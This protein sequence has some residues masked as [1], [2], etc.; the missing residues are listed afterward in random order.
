MVTIRPIE[1]TDEARWRVLWA[2]YLDFYESDVPEDVTAATFARILDPEMPL[3]GVCA[4]DENGQII[5][6][7]HYIFHPSTWSLAGYCYLE[8]LFV[9]P[10]A[11]RSGAGRA[12]IEAV[13]E[14]ARGAGATRVYWN[15]QH[16]NETARALY[17]QLA[18]LSPFV[19]YR[20]QNP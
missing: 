15:T 12:L 14:A 10:A 7:T 19:Q 13:V 9:D 4:V 3:H 11:R 2:G 16:F 17:D 20:I 6:V 18:A 8:D 1:A 5:G